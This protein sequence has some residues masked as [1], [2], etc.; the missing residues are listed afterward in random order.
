MEGDDKPQMAVHSRDGEL[1]SRRSC[2]T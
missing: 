1:D 2:R